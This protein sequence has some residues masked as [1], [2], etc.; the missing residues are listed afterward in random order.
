M[1]TPYVRGCCFVVVV[2]IL[3]CCFF[4]EE[5]AIFVSLHGFGKQSSHLAN[6]L[7]GNS[8][9]HPNHQHIRIHCMLP[10]VEN[11]CHSQARERL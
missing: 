2:V 5:G 11:H 7:P 3:F 9:Y 1:V 4:V 8:T 10:S 6:N